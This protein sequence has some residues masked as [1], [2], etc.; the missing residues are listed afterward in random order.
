MVYAKF[1]YS[2]NVLFCEPTENCE[3]KR[4][5]YMYRVTEFRTA[6]LWAFEAQRRPGIRHTA[7]G[8]PMRAEFH[9]RLNNMH[10]LSD[11]S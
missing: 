6:E 4:K 10:I 2:L 5:L 7:N 9:Y 3:Y 8:A 11:I 1:N